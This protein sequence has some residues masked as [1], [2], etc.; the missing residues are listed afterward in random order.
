[1]GTSDEAGAGEVW[2]KLI[3]A[4]RQKGCH[5]VVEFLSNVHLLG[6]PSISMPHNSSLYKPFVAS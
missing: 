5:G 3:A 2:L 6:Y 1:M 4:L